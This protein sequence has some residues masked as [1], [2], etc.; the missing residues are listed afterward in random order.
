M[1]TLFKT[2][3]TLPLWLLHAVGWSLGW[4]VFALSGVYR[5]RF[6]A[7]ARQAGLVWRQW[8]GAV[9]ESGKLVA[10][11]PRLWLGRPVPVQWVGAQH[12]EEALAL[13]RGVLFLTPHLGCFEVAAQAY[14][15]RYGQVQPL[16]VLFRPP[17]QAWLRQLVSTAR[18]RPGLATAPTTLA[19]VKQMIKALKKSQS[20][21]LLPDQVPPMGMGVWAPF[22][23]RDAYTMTLSARLAQQTGATVLMAWGERLPWG[24]GYRVH[25]QPLPAA[26]PLENA[27]AVRAINAA[28]ESLIRACP[29]QY[30]WGYARYKQPRQEL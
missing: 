24:R 28:L 27:Q 21:A 19:G 17:R 26:L 29:Q 20:L 13:R 3:S 6:L 18:A 4:L 22:F 10:E 7:N 15:Q 30:L 9:G 16:T 12:V 2:L 1:S 5:G 11:L 14:A 8:R 23:G 25:V